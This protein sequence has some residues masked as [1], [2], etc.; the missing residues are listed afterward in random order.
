LTRGAAAKAA[1]GLAVALLLGWWVIKTSA[2]DALVR[3]NPAFAAAIAPNQPDVRLSL[4]MARLDLGTGEFDEAAM[5]DALAGLARAPLAEEPFLFAGLSAARRGRYD[6]AERFLT[7][8]RRRNPRLRPARLFLLDR[9]LR[10]NRMAAAAGEV[11]SLRRLI[12]E[13]SEALAPQLAQLARDERSGGAL[14]RVLAREPELQQAVLE[15]LAAVGTD[16]DLILRVASAAPAR[17]SAEGLPWQRRLLTSLVAR[18]DYARALRLWRSFSGLPAGGGDKAVYDGR[19]QRLPGAAPFNWRLT[20]QSAGGGEYG[21]APALDVEY[22]GRETADL[23][24]QMLVLRPGRYRLR[25]RVE[26]SAKGDDSRLAWRVGCNGGSALLLDLPIREVDAAPR[27]F[28]GEFTVPASCPAQWLRLTGIAGEFPGTQS[29]S[30]SN[31]DISPA[32]AR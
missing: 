32:G 9:Y 29:V 18:N 14:M 23:A 5:R 28:T 4:A 31:L 8:A 2:A 21:S 12:P 22:F 24:E 25:F 26:G 1:A 27:D 30:I 6:E 15:Y 10:Q 19:F 20:S 17:P 16:P 11:V 13:V 7:E 3:R